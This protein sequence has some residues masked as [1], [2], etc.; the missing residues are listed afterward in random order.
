[1]KINTKILAV[2]VML[3][4]TSITPLIAAPEKPKPTLDKVEAAKVDSLLNRLKEIDNMDK[5]SLRPSEKKVLRKEVKNIRKE[6]KEV[7]GG[8]YI[9]VGAII[10]IILL[11][12]L[13]V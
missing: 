9:S 10:I 3:V 12:I 13:L 8:L 1:M 6:I 2:V 4:T 11:L 7:R 5:T